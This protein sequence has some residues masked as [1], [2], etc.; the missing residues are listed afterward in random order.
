MILLV[1]DD[2][3]ILNVQIQLLSNFGFKV[4]AHTCPQQAL[5][6][7]KA[8]PQAYQAILTDYCMP[9]MDGV[10]LIASIHAIRPDLKAILYSGML[11]SDIPK[12]II[13]L[14]KPTRM[15]QLVEILQAG[16]STNKLEQVSQAV[17]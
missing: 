4:E 16:Q 1:D 7:F 15:K 6:Q 9:T 5:Q 11:P 10:T 8:Q 3:A 14:S 13:A 12:H 2:K 17:A